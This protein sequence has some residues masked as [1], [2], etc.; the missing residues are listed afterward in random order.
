[1]A[2][3]G[4]LTTHVLD[5]YH[6]HPAAGMK[7]DLLRVDDA[8]EH[9]LTVHTNA[10]GR[11]DAPLLEN[12]A[13]QEGEYELNFHVRPYFEHFQD[14]PVESPFLNIVP[15]RF[16]VYDATRHYHVPLLISPWAYQTYRGS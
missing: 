7:I 6:G 10:D 8:R 3:K 4:K 14:A 9:L 11:C 16:T 1:M 13:F 15:I 12:H 5:I 2:D